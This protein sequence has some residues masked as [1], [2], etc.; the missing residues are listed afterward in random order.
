MVRSYRA[1]DKFNK[2]GCQKGLWSEFEKTKVQE[3]ML[4]S[5]MEKIFVPLTMYLID[6]TPLPPSSSPY[7]G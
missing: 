6:M 1:S 4:V 7:K 5:K 3:Q 2:K